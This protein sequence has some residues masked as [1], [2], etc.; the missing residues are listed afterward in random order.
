MGYNILRTGVSSVKIAM[1]PY[2]LPQELKPV[3]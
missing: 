2:I 1:I 3:K